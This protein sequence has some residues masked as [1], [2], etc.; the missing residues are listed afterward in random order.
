M[1]T[2]AFYQSGCI[3]IRHSVLEFR[4]QYVFNDKKKNLTKNLFF[5]FSLLFLGYVDSNYHLG[6]KYYNSYFIYYII[7]AIEI[8]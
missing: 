3:I 6:T 5:L 7:L 2:F 8:W 4:D 1:E